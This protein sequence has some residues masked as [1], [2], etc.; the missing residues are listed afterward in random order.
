MRKSGFDLGNGPI[1]AGDAVLCQTDVGLR[2]CVVDEVLQDGDASITY[3]NGEH[4]LVKW[5]QLI[6][7]EWIKQT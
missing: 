2:I 7:P 6:R 5:R 4:A 3:S 1:N